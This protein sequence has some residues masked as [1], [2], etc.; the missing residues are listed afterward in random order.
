MVKDCIKK[1]EEEKKISLEKRNVV[2]SEFNI[3]S[4]E[5]PN[6]QFEINVA[7]EPT[8]GLLLMILVKN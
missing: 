4:I 8:L 3:I 7:K 2:V 6:I 1:R 5:S